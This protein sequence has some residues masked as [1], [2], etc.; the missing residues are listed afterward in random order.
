MPA[1]TGRARS[2][3][4]SRS[5]L[6][7][8]S[9]SARASSTSARATARPSSVGACS[10]ANSSASPLGEGAARA[11]EVPI[12]PNAAWQRAEARI[13]EGDLGDPRRG[14]Q[15]FR[16]YVEE[17]W[18]PHHVIE[19]TTREKYTYYLAADILPE[20]GPM[21]MID[22]LPEHVREWITKMQAKGASAWTIQYWWTIQYCK[23]S[24]LNSIFTTAVLKD[25]VITFHPSRGV[26]TPTVPSTPRQII[27]PEQFD[28]IYQP[29]SDADVQLL[30]ET[31][32]E[33]PGQILMR[34]VSTFL[35]PLTLR[36]TKVLSTFAFL[37]SCSL[38]FSPIILSQGRRLPRR[39]KLCGLTS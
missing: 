26:R 29:L 19:P 7:S 15:T 5:C 25:R 35:T 23:Y 6:N 3:Q 28:A 11:P 37:C 16:S 30:V 36:A 18:L 33:D 2:R 22:I 24:I 13:A 27:A 38:K 1:R 39:F 8:R 34:L 4:P 32:V 17:K 14:R 31:A 12:A 10:K 20:F 21:R 9:A